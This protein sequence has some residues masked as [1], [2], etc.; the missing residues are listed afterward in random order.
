MGFLIALSAFGGVILIAAVSGVLVG[1]KIVADCMVE[2]IGYWL[3]PE[4]KPAPDVPENIIENAFNV[5]AGKYDGNQLNCKYS[6]DFATLNE[7][8]S[9]YDEVSAINPWAY[10][11]YKGRVLDLFNKEFDPFIW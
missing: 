11:R 3:L 1:L 2:A 9:S 8:I 4:N 10:I 5:I 7:A 6:A